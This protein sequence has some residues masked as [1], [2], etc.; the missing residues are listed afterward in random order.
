MEASTISLVDKCEIAFERAVRNAIS[1]SYQSLQSLF[2]SEEY[3]RK[4]Y[5]YYQGGAV[6][7]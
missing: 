5:L 2:T 6:H 3:V 1:F 7:K 4:E